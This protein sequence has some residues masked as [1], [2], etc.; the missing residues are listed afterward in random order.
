[1]KAIMGIQDD[2]AR[3]G[4]PNQVRQLNR[5]VE[6]KID[7]WSKRWKLQGVHVRCQHCG[8]KQKL[9][10][11]GKPFLDQHKPGCVFSG[12]RQIPFGELAEILSGCHL[13][14]WDEE[15]DFF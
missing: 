14:L 12:D 11:A 10:D 3:E 7:Q 5:S 13:E 15:I 8:G 4:R 1:M 2:F 9:S 6:V